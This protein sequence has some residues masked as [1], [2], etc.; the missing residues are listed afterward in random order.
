MEI[1]GAKGR[2]VVRID[3]GGGDDTF[4]NAS[5]AGASKTQFYDSRG[6]N[7][8]VKGKGAK[9]DESA[10]TSV[11]R[12]TLRGLTL[13]QRYAPRLGHGVVYVPDDYSEPGSGAV[14]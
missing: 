2:I 9:V 3:G 6:K 4:T 11:L 13:T 5:E 14:S 12:H 1:S 8:F 10:A 7:Q